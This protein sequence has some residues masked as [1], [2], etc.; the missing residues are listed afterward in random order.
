MLLPRTHPPTRHAL[1][2]HTRTSLSAAAIKPCTSCQSTLLSFSPLTQHSSSRSAAPEQQQQRWRSR[3]VSLPAASV[4]QQQP[5][6][7]TAAPSSSNNSPS[8]AGSSILHNLLVWLVSNGRCVFAGKGFRLG[9]CSSVRRPSGALL[10]S[11]SLHV[12]CAGVCAATPLPP[13]R[14]AR[15]WH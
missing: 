4:P 9:A 3:C 5:G 7:T 15:H 1:S 8:E 11:P 2:N 13:Y 6:T 14:C 10:S 12:V